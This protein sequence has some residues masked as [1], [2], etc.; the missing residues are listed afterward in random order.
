MLMCVL[1]LSLGVGLCAWQHDRLRAYDTDMFLAD[2]T[3]TRGS[4]APVRI[5][6]DG[7][8]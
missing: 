4:G 1:A 6:N 7:K 8:V 2:V 3:N 5:V